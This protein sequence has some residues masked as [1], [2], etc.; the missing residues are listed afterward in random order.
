MYVHLTNY[1]INKHNENFIFN[2]S[3][4]DD[5]IGHKRSMTS[6]FNVIILFSFTP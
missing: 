3:S 2:K 1:S 6:V 5:N 4:K